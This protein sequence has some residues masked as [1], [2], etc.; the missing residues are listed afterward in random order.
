MSEAENPPADDVVVVDHDEAGRVEWRFERAFF[1]SGWEC[2][3]GRGC[4]GILDDDATELE[5]GCCSSAPSWPTRT[6]LLVASAALLGRDEAQFHDLIRS[7][8]RS[9]YATSNDHTGRRQACVFFN[10]PGFPGGTGC[11]LHLAAQ[12]GSESV[13]DWKP[14]VCWQVPLKCAGTRLPIAARW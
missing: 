9:R 2:L 11:A 3:W 12:R 14:A 6:T 7:S 5:R 4:R 8:L 13:L 10:R 1:A